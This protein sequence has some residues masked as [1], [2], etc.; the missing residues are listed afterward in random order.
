MTS[1][2]S[3]APLA[4]ATARVLILGS[5]PGTASLQAG[6][7]YAHPRNAFWPI[8]EAVL[9]VGVALPYAERC[10][11]LTGRGVAVWDVLRSCSRPGSLDAAIDSDSM[12]ANDFPRFFHD[13]PGIR[14]VC[15]NG[16]T[17]YQVF[18]RRVVPMLPDAWRELPLLRLPSTS[19]AH[20]SLSVAQKT[21]HWRSALQE[22]G[23][24]VS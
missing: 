24:V 5:M 23:V 8:M 13:H 15:C 4:Q 10:E 3:F 7:Y 16:G 20:A 17:A 6:Q 11:R 21:S 18:R 14:G 19:P 9:G 22:L 1:V 12:V 2:H